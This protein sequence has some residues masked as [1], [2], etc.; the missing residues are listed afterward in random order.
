[1]NRQ[2]AG[3][4]SQLSIYPF[5]IVKTRI[6]RSHHLIVAKSEF[7]L[8]M[9]MPMHHGR[10]WLERTRSSHFLTQSATFFVSVAFV[11]FIVA[12]SLP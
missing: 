6:V 7:E 4:T 11:D 2:V 8:P 10:L 3:A 5:E 12:S 1:M 9:P